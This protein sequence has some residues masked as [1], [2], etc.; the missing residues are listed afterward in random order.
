LRWVSALAQAVPESQSGL[1]GAFGWTDR[2]RLT[3]VVAHFLKSTDAFDRLLGIVACALH[4]VDPGLIP[5]RHLQDPHPAVRARALRTAGELGLRS[6]V[7][8]VTASLE[9]DDPYCRFWAA[10]SGVLLGDRGRTLKYLTE[11]ALGIEQLTPK[12]KDHA[13]QVCLQVMAVSEATALLR[14]ITQLAP[15]SR[16]VLRGG[17]W[18]GDPGFIPALINQMKDTVSARLAGE[19]FSLITGADLAA[20]DLEGKPPQDAPTGPNDDPNDPN[21]DM[22]ADDG[23]PW[24]DPERVSQWWAKHQ[25]AFSAGTRYFVGKPVSG[26]HCREVLRNG[27]QRQRIAAALHRCLIEPGTV[28]FEWRAPVHRQKRE[29]ATMS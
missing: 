24:P 25:G 11:V 27:F 14:Q 12:L 8:T 9:D 23:L 13:L 19:A 2:S 5:T 17:G 3:D 29:L 7:S 4:R 10:R 6:L 15:N 22:D 1:F 21:V 26:E 20:L 18:V 16:S 28:L